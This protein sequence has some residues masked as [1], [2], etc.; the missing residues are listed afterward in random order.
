MSLTWSKTLSFLLGKNY[1]FI[2]VV[3][4]RVSSKQK[5]SQKKQTILLVFRKLF[6]EYELSV[7][8]QKRC[9]ILRKII[10]TWFTILRGI[11]LNSSYSGLLEIVLD[12]SGFRKGLNKINKNLQAL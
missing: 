12:I 3:L 4:V 1:N 6:C 11:L 5:I 8:I 2:D 9:K 7:K 10:G